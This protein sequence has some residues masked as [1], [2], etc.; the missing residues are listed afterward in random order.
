MKGNFEERQGVSK[1]TL[2]FVLSYRSNWGLWF[3]GNC[4]LDQ[5]KVKLKN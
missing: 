1:E 5:M 2:G 4:F 3:F